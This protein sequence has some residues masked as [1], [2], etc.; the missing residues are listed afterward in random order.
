MEK[1]DLNFPVA[2]ANGWPSSAAVVAEL[3]KLDPVGHA[4][5]KHMSY[6]PGDGP[7]VSAAEIAAMMHRATAS[8]VMMSMSEVRRTPEAALAAVAEYSA[9]PD[10]EVKVRPIEF[11]PKAGQWSADVTHREWLD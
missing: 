10:Y 1:F 6:T 2:G 8:A 5:M 11:G 4:K 7:A 9:D 3:R